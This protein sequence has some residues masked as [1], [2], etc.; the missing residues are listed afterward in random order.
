MRP[1]SFWKALSSSNPGSWS[2]STRFC[3]RDTRKLRKS[4]PHTGSL[5]R[6]LI[7]THTGKKRAQVR[8][9]G[10]LQRSGLAADPPSVTATHSLPP[11]ACLSFMTLLTLYLPPRLLRPSQLQGD[12]SALSFH[13]RVALCVASPTDAWMG[14][15][16]LSTLLTDQLPAAKTVWPQVSGSPRHVGEDLAQAKCS[17][18]T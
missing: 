10:K 12:L 6:D 8:S 18:N 14:C 2:N 13:F 7:K 5:T 16:C 17:V 4:R 11:K 1:I 15:T 9:N 3:M